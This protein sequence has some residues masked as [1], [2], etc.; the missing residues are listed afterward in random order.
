MAKI[1]IV[2]D[3]VDA[4]NILRLVLDDAGYE[5]LA[6]ENGQH[7]LNIARQ[8]RPD[9]IIADVLM[10]V[11]DGYAFYKELKEDVLT[12]NIPV[13]ILS[14][15][16]AMQS[17]FESVGADCFLE[18]PVPPQKL[19]E[20]I[21]SLLNLSE[22]PTHKKQHQRVLVAG[23]YP[24]VADRIADYVRS[25]GHEVKTV[26]KASD[27]IAQSVSF[28]EDV[29]ILEVQIENGE[30]AQ[31]VIKAVRL[32]PYLKDVPVVLYSYYH[33]SDLGNSDFRDRVLG[34]EKAKDACMMAGGT[35]YFDRYNEPVFNE[36]IL[37][38]I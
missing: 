22:L 4:V 12:K 25:L 16:G 7:G 23:T 37:K 20:I 3:E 38:Y 27:V 34:I 13:I 30:S 5:V 15:R 14:A 35:E 17:A 29:L 18:K 33:V 31:D 24:E 28:R 26:Y 9:L 10:P 6:A 8:N 36:Q 1:L 19:L 2:D 21:N 11:M 32:L